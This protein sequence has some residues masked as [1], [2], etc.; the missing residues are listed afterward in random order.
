MSGKSSSTWPPR[1]DWSCGTIRNFPGAALEQLLGLGLAG[2]VDVGHDR[3]RA[4]AVGGFISDR[5]TDEGVHQGAFADLFAADESDEVNTG[6]VG[7]R[8][9]H[10]GVG[11]E[12]RRGGCSGQFHRFADE[13]FGL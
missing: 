2:A 12:K 3:F 1:R 4:G 9:Q 8:F 6:L 11:V 10:G 5:G 13:L 7:V